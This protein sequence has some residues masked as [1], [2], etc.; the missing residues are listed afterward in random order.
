MDIFKK[1]SLINLVAITVLATTSL[2][3]TGTISASSVRL[4]EKPST[5]AEILT[6]IGED[7]KVEVIEDSGD[8]LKVKY[9]NQT[10][11]V[12]KKYVKLGDEAKNTNTTNT[13][14]N[15]TK[16]SNTTTENKTTNTN[17]NTTTEP[18]KKEP[19]KV[20]IK[21]DGNV[22]LKDSYLRSIPS[23]IAKPVTQLSK[24]TIVKIVDRI[25][26]WVK[27][28]DEDLTGWIP[29]EKLGDEVV[30]EKEVEETEPEKKETETTKKE[31]TKKEE[32]KQEETKK[33]EEK[34]SSTTKKNGVVSVDGARVRE[35]GSKEAEIIGSLDK[36]DEVKIEATEGDWYKVSGSGI[37]SGYVHKSLVLVTD[38]SS[39]GTNDRDKSMIGEEQQKTE[40]VKEEKVEA[41]VAA[42]APAPAPSGQGAAVVEF[43]KQYLGYPYVAAGKNPSTGF[44]CSGFTQYVFSNF[45]VSL[46]GSAASQTGNGAEV[47][48]A[49]LQMGDLVLFYDDGYTKVG[50]A[51]IY[52]SDGNFIH[53]A[54]PTRGVVIDNLN[55]SSYYNS[56][57]VTARRIVQ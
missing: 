38:V 14:K 36:G 8:W 10:G 20:T 34:S 53:A 7:S 24:G 32:T 43:A 42:A 37:S 40:E 49:N 41:P 48:R 19:E 25:G 16:T 39:R 54:N 29:Q 35:S 30:I 33:T 11:Y 21:G 46:G 47:A 5:E 27:V 44:D 56:R 2:A 1:V 28:T 18:E 57:Y 17:T 12:F 6:S 50:H 22:V 26:N 23:L 9:D 31:E 15:E 4:R 13:T 52:I 45:G 3:S 51:G 55:S